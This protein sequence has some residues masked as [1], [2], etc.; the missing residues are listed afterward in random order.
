MNNEKEEIRNHAE[1]ECECDACIKKRIDLINGFLSAV[2]DGG[3]FDQNEAEK[4]INWIIN[5]R[6]TIQENAVLTLL[7]KVI[8][9]E[10]GQLKRAHY[11]MGSLISMNLL[12]TLSILIKTFVF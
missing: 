12:A 5:S 9:N 2:K 8:W 11:L 3:E 7:L 10:L 6:E 4:I 1:D